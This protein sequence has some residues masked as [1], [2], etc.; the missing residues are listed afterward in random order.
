MINGGNSKRMFENGSEVLRFDCHLHTV[1][2]KE[3]IYDGNANHFVANYIAKLKEEDIAVGVITN[4][5]K[6]DV[7]QYN[8][9]KKKAKKEDIYILPGVELSVKEGAS[10]VHVLIVFNPDEW[11]CNGIDH[12]SRSIDAMFLGID[13][14]GN[15][16]T[17]TEKD[18]LTVI[19][20]LDRQ[21]KDYFII[22]AHVEQKKGFW[23]ECGGTLIKKLASE[24]IF[25]KRVLGF[26][27]ART[28]DKIKKVHDWM[29]YDVAFVEG[30]DPKSIDEIGKDDKK[31]YIKIG[32]ASY[33]AV[34]YALTDFENR[35]FDEKP[36][37]T[38][39]YIKQMKCIGGKLDNQVFSP[40]D[41]LNTLI[42]I[43]GSGKSSVLEV[44]RYALNKDPAQDDKYKNDLVKAVLGSGGKVEL[45][46]VDKY[47]KEYTLNRIYGERS[48]LYDANGDILG[49]PVETILNNPLYFGQKDLA[50]TRK[51]YEYELLNRIIGD[52]VP[53]IEDEKN[54]VQN[55]IITNIEKLKAL[56]DIPGQI[57]DLSSENASLE[58]KLK[59]YQEKG[60]DEKLKKQTSCNNDLVKLETISDWV[61]EIII[62]LEDAYSKDG[63]ELLSLQNYIS[64]YNSDIFDE[65]G[66]YITQAN[67]GLDSVGQS[68]GV[69]KQ[70][71]EGI[72]SVKEQ[73]IKKIDSLKE[74][75]AEI[76]REI[77]D[78]QL[79]ADSYVA[80][81]KKLAMNKEKVAKLTESLKSKDSICAN[82]KKEFNNR[83]ELL[84]NNYFAYRN[85]AEVINKQQDQLAVNIEFKGDKD[86]LK[87]RMMQFFKGT[88]LSE[89]KYS[90]MT[91]EFSDLSAIVEDY[92][93]Y[94]GSRIK[95]YCTDTIYSKVA[96]KIEDGYKEMLIDDT[97]DKIVITYHGKVLSKHSLGQRA[98]AL[99]LFILTQH[100]SD[101]IIVDQPEDDLDNQ[102]IYEE[103][104]QTIKV[105]KKDMQF[106][107]ATHN[108]N[109][110]V[111]GD[112][113]RV[114]TTHH[115]EDGSIG[116]KCGTI[117]S[118]ETH[119]DIINIME[120]GAEAF[121]RRNEIYVSWE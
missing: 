95:R 25:R 5:N 39:G 18:L 106:I 42:G 117:D 91:N 4:H 114:V 16:N 76:K 107:F 99:I 41:E 8:A 111:L 11:L 22:C 34:K 52:K 49:I 82:L 58:H 73:L 2:D 90:D 120:G 12:I 48:S 68:I 43:R 94:E 98:S 32:E 75:F 116:L 121:R 7:V 10:S 104:I 33:A 66:K 28:R 79:D 80:N 36:E 77:N 102:V 9:I 62:E 19:R 44:L 85:A 96:V 59:I 61:K 31:S 70:A 27:K 113:E 83:N 81:K 112:A 86:S 57:A 105:E 55:N 97:P 72:N 50:L 100:D 37:I 6:F 35:V 109:I 56:T 23:N 118:E 14:P 67:I 53:S 40:S 78:E 45:V 20:E 71:L 87:E 46:I 30:S 54:T 64:E 92:Y 1:N 63:R 15:E 65:L 26:Q 51:G 21:N 110:P 103:L 93:L 47:K 84:R 13:N 74:E 101:V 119:N 29:G 3:F 60:L 17:F 69:I 88:G 24:A 89:I 38:H 108:A 115:N